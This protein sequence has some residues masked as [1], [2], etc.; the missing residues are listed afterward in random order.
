MNHLLLAFQSLPSTALHPTNE[1][2]RLALLAFK[3]RIVGDPLGILTSWNE[4]SHFCNWTGVLCS[5]KHQ[6]RVTVLNLASQKLF[7]SIAPHI[8]NLSFLREVNLSSNSF[9]GEI[10]PQ[11]GRL[12]RLRYLDLD[13]NNFQGKIPSNIYV[14][15]FEFEDIELSYNNLT[16]KIPIELQ[17][18]SKSLQIIQ[19]SA[20]QLTGSIPQML[21]NA[22]SLIYLSLARNNLQGRIPAEL[23]KLLKLKFLQ[24]SDNNLSGEVPLSIYNLSSLVFQ[25]ALAK[26][27]LHG[28]I[29][30]DV[31]F[32][33]PKLRRFYVDFNYFYGE[34]P[35]SFQNATNLEG[36]DLGENNF[37]GVIPSS[38]GSLKNL[39]ILILSNNQLE[40]AEGEGLSFLTSLTN[41]TN[42]RWLG[43]MENHFKGE[44]P[45]SIANLSVKLEGFTI[46]GNQISGKIP[47][48]IG[49]LV[50]LTKLVI[51][52]S[53]VTGEI[54]STIGKLKRVSE[55]SLYG[56]RISGPIPSSLGNIT[57]LLKLQLYDNNLSDSIPPSLGNCSRLEYLYMD[58]NFFLGNIPEQIF[59]L[60]HVIEL[61]LSWNSFTGQLAI[62]L[63][64]GKMT[65]IVQLNV[66][67]N[68]LSGGIPRTL[69]DCLM[70][71]GLW[72]GD[73]LFEGGIPSS[74]NNLKSLVM[75]DLSN[76]KLSGKIPE[77]FQNFSLLQYLN[78]SFNDFEG[79]LPTGRIFGNVSM[80]F[81]AGN[82][83]LCGGIHQ[84]GLP[85]CKIRDK[86]L[87]HLIIMISV[88]VLCSI[89][90][91]V[92]LLVIFAYRRSK[93]KASTST[94]VQD[95]EQ[96][97][98]I[99]YAE[100]SQATDEFSS[101]NLIG[102]GSFGSV[103]KGILSQDGM[104]VAV[105]V[106]NL[107]RKGATK[108]FMAECE[109]LRNIRHRNLIKI[110]TVCSSIDF[111][112][113]DFK[114]L[115]YE[116]M[117]NGSLE[118]WLHPNEDQTGAR[119]L[120]LIQRLNIAIEVASAIE[121]L[122]NYCQPSV[123]HGDLKPSNV[124][125]D[126]E[127]VSHVGDFGL[128][129]FL[130]VSQN[131]SSSMGVKG[132]IGYV[133]PE[134][135]MSTKISKAGDV[136]S[137]G[138][139]LLEMITGKA[140]TDSMF[141]DNFTIHQ[142]VKTRLPERVI[143]IIDPSLLPEVQEAENSKARNMRRGVGVLES[144]LAVV[145]V[146]VVCS[147]KS[148]RERMEMKDVAAKLYAIRDKFL[149]R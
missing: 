37:S 118:E 137:F 148:P 91:M 141:K 23:G 81:V 55:L 20:N 88:I 58:N 52:N 47:K 139:L 69:G 4:S 109:T 54:P 67:H 41:C 93:R 74:F 101:S 84:L 31:G 30:S 72:M 135:G 64:V 28:Q 147:M 120:S 8:G 83:R 115:V 2:D 79:E 129:R 104:P 80:I 46:G 142:L 33:L 22:S 49:N 102:E 131:Q 61:D 143:D 48:E 10:P 112:G 123:V 43:L 85:S 103:Y 105:K 73:N 50:G 65:N 89:F 56:N 51:I 34:I 21:G 107:K 82:P 124:L 119:K 92:S 26:N 39:T 114:A 25:L 40:S 138:I 53:N 9:T 44:L 70:L 27:Q 126:E 77:Y 127:M 36:L 35:T 98:K 42:L 130:S 96:Y 59:S 97:P 62:D 134:Y 5:K 146:G 76:N 6:G 75:L 16:G 117:Q 133:A 106:L 86:K 68:R 13:Y 108:S 12:L 7:G 99:S 128:A 145:E 125:L 45:I 94:D 122:H 57:Q 78:L 111:R 11:I 95:P 87:H 15:L 1:N 32:T 19:V 17:N 3:D 18:I 121:Y 116:F 132:T 136:Y 29:P 110:I 113:T 90:L 149:H 66:S 144:L 100:L 71:E 60:S 24:L 63:A 140:P 14:I 38:F